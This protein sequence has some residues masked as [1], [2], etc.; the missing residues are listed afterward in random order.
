M[1]DDEII[2][3]LLALSKPTFFTLDWDFCHR[4]LCHAKYALVFLDVK[5]DEAAIFIR[6]FLRQ[7]VFATQRKRLG[8]IVRVSYGGLTFW[9]LHSEAETFYRW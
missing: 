6:R 2:P 9:Q 5:R 8:K 1:K 7:P 3:F 4:D